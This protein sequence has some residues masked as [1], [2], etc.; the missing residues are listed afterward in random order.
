MKRYYGGEVVKRGTYLSLKRKDLVTIEEEGELLLCE[1]NDSYIKIQ[2]LV[3]I[4]VGP[5]MGLIYVIFLPFLSFAMIFWVVVNKAWLGARRFGEGLLE[6][7]ASNRRP[8]VA[9]FGWGKQSKKGKEPRLQ[10][11][12]KEEKKSE[13]LGLCSELEKEIAKKREEEGKG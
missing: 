9:Y 1:G 6:V 8:N 10:E 5:L 13:T 2:P 12:L 11:K 4:V 7:A 3:M